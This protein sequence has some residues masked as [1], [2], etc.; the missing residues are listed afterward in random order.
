MKS[1]TPIIDC[2]VHLP[3]INWQKNSSYSFFDNPQ[4]AINYL[5]ST[6]VSGVIFNTFESIF[7]E[8]ETELWHG[9]LSAIEIF[10]ANQN[11]LVPSAVV[12]PLWIECSIKIL[13]LFRSF[14]FYWVGELLPESVDFADSRWD[15]L[16]EDMTKHNHVLQLHGVD[17]VFEVAKKYPSLKIIMS[18]IPN[19]LSKFLEFDNLYLDISGKE[20]GLRVGKLEKAYQILGKERI[21]FGSD[22]AI[23]EPLAYISRINQVIPPEEHKYIFYKNLLTLDSNQ[24]LRKIIKEDI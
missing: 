18:H 10:N 16:F 17:S 23:Y 5:K 22:F 13:N 21:L 14:N 15:L 19:N 11:F 2:H 20:G 4:K 3:S 24:S 12:S 1:F 6:P 8:S 7:A 9:N